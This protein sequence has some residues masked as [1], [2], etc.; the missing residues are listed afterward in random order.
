MLDTLRHEARSVAS[1]PAIVLVMVGGVVLYG[2]LYN[3]LYRPNVVREAPVVVVDHS[4]TPLSRH[5]VESVDATP[6][7]AVVAEAGD[8]GQA[9]GLMAQGK[10][11]G[12]IIIPHDL[13]RRIGLGEEALFVVAA[14]TA[15]FLYY[16]AIQSGTLGALQAI[17]HDLA[18]H[19]AATLLPTDKLLA[20]A[21]AKPVEVVGTPLFNSTKGYGK[22]LLPAV[23][24]VIICQ[25]MLMVVCLRTDGEGKHCKGSLLC[26]QRPPRISLG[27][28]LAVVVGQG[29]LYT[30]L[31]GLFSLFLL[32]LLPYLFGLP[33]LA[34]WQDLFV[35][36]A[37][38]LPANALFALCFASLF[39]DGD[40]ALLVVTFFSLGLL[41]L[42]GISYP[43]EFMPTPWVVLHHL[44][45]APVGILAYVKMNSMG[46]SL[47]ECAPQL[48]TLA[49]QIP[50]YLLLALA[51]THHRLNKQSR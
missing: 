21:Q 2:L 9:R 49:L 3:F 38:L 46:A 17:D 27:D 24:I 18:P 4:H 36:G 47:G 16:E 13:E 39:R 25:T 29:A 19:V 41:L 8:I 42:G 22:Y 28:T 1:S 5:L 51:L 44:L 10:A 20:V 11:E 30:F 23:L 15:E 37:L 45:P 7:V 32:G 26:G 48:L 6:Q 43:L 50:A 31:Y 33:H 40:G 35:L 14:S 34:R 12:T